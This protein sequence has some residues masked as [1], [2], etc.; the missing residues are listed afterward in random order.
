MVPGAYRARLTTTNLVV[1]GTLLVDGFVA[2]LWKATRKKETARVEVRAFAPLAREARAAAVEEGEA[3][4]RF[5]EPD[6][7]KVEV[8]FA[9]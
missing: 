5:L 8:A 3:L 1:P 9:R 2:G 7:A 6:A 4:A